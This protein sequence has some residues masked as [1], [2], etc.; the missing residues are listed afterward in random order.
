MNCGNFTPW[1]SLL[2]PRFKIKGFSSASFAELVK[3]KVLEKA[4]EIADPARGNPED[5]ESVEE[6]HTRN[7][8]SKESSLWEEFDVDK[9][10]S[11]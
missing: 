4:E 1:P 11:D 7:K 2:D 6:Y 9:D 10:D 8:K 3:S 5:N